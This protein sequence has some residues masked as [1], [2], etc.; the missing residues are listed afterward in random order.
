MHACVCTCIRECVLL[1]VCV[2]VCVCVSVCVCVCACVCTCTHLN[3]FSILLNL[4]C[5]LFLSSMN[6][7]DPFIKIILHYSCTGQ[8][9]TAHCSLSFSL[10]LDC[11]ASVVLICTPPKWRIWDIKQPTNNNSLSLSLSLSPSL[12]LT[13]TTLSKESNCNRLRQVGTSLYVRG[14]GV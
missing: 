1:C 5:Y 3:L 12:S 6:H 11:L 8:I 7:F 10:S 2:C 14:V 4:I 9:C 13:L